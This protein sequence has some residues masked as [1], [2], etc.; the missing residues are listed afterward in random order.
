[1][2]AYAP[3]SLPARVLLLGAGELGKELT[4]SLKR[5]GC[6]VVAC[7][8][9]VGA[10]AMQVADE[11]RIFD[12]TDPRALAEVLEA[13]EVDLIVPEVEAIATELLLAA[14]DAGRARV[15]PNAHAVRTTMDRQAI[16]ALADCLPDVRVG[17]HR[18][19][20][21]ADQ[22][23]AALD[24]LR[25]PVFVKPTMSSSG[26]GQ[27]LV[28][29]RAD[30]RRAW[31]TAARGARAATGRVIVE[32]RIDFDY[33]ITLLTVRWWSHRE[34]RVRTSFC[35]PIGHRQCDGDYVESWQPADMSP[36]ALASAQ[37]MAAAMTGALAEAGPGPGLGLFGAEFF[38][39]GDRVW[40]SE[41]SPRPHD[42]GM[43]TMATQDLNEFDLHARA[44][45]GLPVDAS[46][47]CPGA[48]AVIKSTAPAPAPRYVGVGD[49]LDLGADVRIFGKPV[50]RAGRRVGVVTVRGATVDEARATARKAA[51][52]VRI[53]NYP[54]LQRDPRGREMASL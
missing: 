2:I 8:S 38:V 54:S 37:R 44:I 36:A 23:R 53:E 30:A 14:E 50:S 17:A 1:M 40:F 35:E 42:T 27:T 33:E 39:R 48:S 13:V 26:H 5:L 52:G 9:Y 43:V 46:L 4:I 15:V 31:D 10:P 51:A 12:M 18:F 49:A 7:D 16:R 32:E 21:S 47:R 24:E 28:R 29:T 6:L 19:A 45:L 11:A 25:L 20:S 22:L 41:L 34:G 3:S